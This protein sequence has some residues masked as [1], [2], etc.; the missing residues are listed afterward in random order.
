[1][2]SYSLT[3]CYLAEAMAR[4]ITEIKDW[5]LFRSDDAT[6]VGILFYYLEGYPITR[7]QVG[8]VYLIYIT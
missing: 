4:K 7:Y 1:M 8:R 2:D 5:N 3:Y 6:I